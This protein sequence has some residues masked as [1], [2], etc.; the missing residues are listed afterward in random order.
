MIPC[1]II[2]NKKADTINTKTN[3]TTIN[4]KDSFKSSFKL[5]PMAS[6]LYSSFENNKKIKEIIIS[7]HK[8]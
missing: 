3:G 5:V 8:R 4:F 6:T 1:S 7:P 2:T